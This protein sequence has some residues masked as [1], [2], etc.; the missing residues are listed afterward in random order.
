MWPRTPSVHSSGLCMP[1]YDPRGHYCLCSIDGTLIFPGFGTSIIS[2]MK[3]VMKLSTPRLIKAEALF[4]GG[5]E[6]PSS[7][8]FIFLDPRGDCSLSLRGVRERACSSR[9]VLS[10]STLLLLLCMFRA[11]ILLHFALV[12]FLYDAYGIRVWSLSGVSLSGPLSPHSLPVSVR[13]VS[14]EIIP[15]PRLSMCQLSGYHLIELGDPDN[16]LLQASLHLVIQM[17][18][19][20]FYVCHCY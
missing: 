5:P 3:G 4:F 2:R 9:W 11:C 14:V 17:R 1:L 8:F 6:L 13:N 12:I 19:Y 15:D 20:P 7:S 10:H 18:Q 16:E